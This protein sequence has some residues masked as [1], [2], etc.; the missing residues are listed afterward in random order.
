MILPYDI[1]NTFL[2]ISKKQW[3]TPLAWVPCASLAY[4]L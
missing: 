4:K 2:Y 1:S 3:D